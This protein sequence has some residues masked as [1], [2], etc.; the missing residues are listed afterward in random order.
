LKNKKF[1]IKEIID[2]KNRNNK[3]NII[4]EK[5]DEQHI[6]NKNFFATF[7]LNII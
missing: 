5:Y 7:H 6:R 2:L 4:M 3:I 1:E